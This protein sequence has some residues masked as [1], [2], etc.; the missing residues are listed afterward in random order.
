M[1]PKNGKL[2]RAHGLPKI[3]KD[4]S[5]I[6][7]FRPI[8]DT[9]GIPHYS[10]GK[11]VTNLLDPLSINKFTLKDSLDAVNKIKSISPHLFDDGYNYV[12]FD[13]ESLFT[14]VPIKR[15][16]DIILKRIYIDKVT[17]TNLKKRSMKKLLLDTCTKTAFTFTGVIYEQRDNVCMGSSLGPLLANVI[18]TDLEEEVIKPLINDNTI[19]FYA[20]Y[21][22]GTLFVIKRKDVCH[23][24]NLLN[25]FDPNLHLKN[26]VLHFLDLKL[27]SNGISV[28]RKN[29]NTGLCT[30]FSSYVPWIHRTA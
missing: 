11:F 21:V 16:I 13:V 3:H 24:Q 8:V 19:N 2:A 29:T 22:D 7:K 15:A 20:R 6:P 5:N 26:V 25:N 1:T 28:F 30:H 18:M 23:I 4:Y 27:S 10:A 12:Y 9:T 17:S 14:N